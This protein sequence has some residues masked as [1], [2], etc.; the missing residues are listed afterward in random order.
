[1]SPQPEFKNPCPA[2]LNTR[3]MFG[4]E[5]T[6]LLLGQNIDDPKN[7]KKGNKNI[8]ITQNKGKLHEQK[9]IMLI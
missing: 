5:G 4:R 6:F 7:K 8:K 2:N 9:D 1:M 3:A